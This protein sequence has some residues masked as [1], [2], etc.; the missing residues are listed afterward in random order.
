MREILFK[1]KTPT[2][3]RW[4]VGY[5][6]KEPITCGCYIIDI[7]DDIAVRELRSTENAEQ[8]AYLRSTKVIRESVGQYTGLKDKNALPGPCSQGVHLGV[9][10]KQRCA[11][12]Q[13]QGKCKSR[14]KFHAVD[15]TINKS[16]PRRLIYARKRKVASYS[17]WLNSSGNHVR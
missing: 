16:P 12:H 6:A 4:I 9:R 10:G 17:N 5:L 2:T 11:Q 7:T 8:N 1:G 3:S 14:G 15:Y 13:R